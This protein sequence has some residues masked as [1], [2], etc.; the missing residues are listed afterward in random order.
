M[1]IR[2]IAQAIGSS[3]ATVHRTLAALPIID[4]TT[5]IATDRA[6]PTPEHDSNAPARN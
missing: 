5:A 3:R 4:V 6:N 1:S 2:H